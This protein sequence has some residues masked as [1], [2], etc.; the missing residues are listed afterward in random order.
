[1]SEETEDHNDGTWSGLKKTIIGLLTTAVLGAGGVIT[2]KFI[3]TLVKNEVNSVVFTCCH[4]N[5]RGPYLASL[6]KEQC[7]AKRIDFNIYVMHPGV[8]RIHDPKYNNAKTT[9]CIS[10]E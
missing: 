5:S 9:R 3:G 10:L 6:F 4:S 1:M 7:R 8:C 2:N